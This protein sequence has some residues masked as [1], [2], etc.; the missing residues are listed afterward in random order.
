MLRKP[1]NAVPLALLVLFALVAASCSDSTSPSGVSLPDYTVISGSVTENSDG[2]I[3]VH[4]DSTT[5]VRFDA[6]LA[7]DT[8]RMTVEGRF[9]G[10]HLDL[11]LYGNSDLYSSWDAFMIR[12]PSNEL[13][14]NLIHPTEGSLMNTTLPGPYEVGEDFTVRFEVD[15][16]DSAPR[17]RI[18][19]PGDG[20]ADAPV[21][22]SDD[23]AGGSLSASVEMYAGLI[24]T[25]ATIRRVEFTPI[26]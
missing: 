12:L 11:V 24:L 8:A 6:P 20:F 16:S 13:F 2:S 9:D 15:N 7:G 25:G 4:P 3:S 19:A 18:W 23:Y 22:D 26:P 1:T 5:F 10:T 14:V 21:F 17:A